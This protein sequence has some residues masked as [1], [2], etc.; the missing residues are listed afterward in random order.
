VRLPFPPNL[1][2]SCRQGSFVTF[3]LVVLQSGFVAV[4]PIFDEPPFQLDN[5]MSPLSTGLLGECFRR[6]EDFFYHAFSQRSYKRTIFPSWRPGSFT[7]AL[8]FLSSGVAPPFSF[9]ASP[10]LFCVIQM[11][12]FCSLNG[13]FFA[14]ASS[15]IGSPI[16]LPFASYTCFF[17][18][19]RGG[20]PPYSP[21]PP[22]NFLFTSFPPWRF[23]LYN[24]LHC[25]SP[26]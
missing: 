18:C 11:F 9:N 13:F 4:L 2:L 21:A 14:P 22:F 3:F 5:L 15:L 10:I 8:C 17:L 19:I 20:T 6:S 25:R 26:A 23:S 7:I 16:R 12:S 1:R 24:F